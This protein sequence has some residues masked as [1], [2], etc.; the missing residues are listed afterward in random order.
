MRA[1]AAGEFH[2]LVSTVIVEVGLD[3]PNA[4]IMVIEH[5]ERF[6]MA[7]LHQLRGRIGRGAH[8]ATCAI[9]SD[10]AQEGLGQRL[11]AFVQTTDGFKLAEQDLAQRGPGHL[12][13]RTQSGWWRFRIADLARD[14]TLLES[15]R[16]EADAVIAHDPELS[17]SEVQPLRE[18]LDR[19]RHA[20]P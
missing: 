17:A 6:G 1:F 13:E 15:A 2:L 10:A 11:S 16:Q 20:A 8:P 14:Q 4:T 9:I 19:F 12:L 7:Q 5:P 3:V 18:R